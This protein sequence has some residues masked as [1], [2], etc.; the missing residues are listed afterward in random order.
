[1]KRW[2]SSLSARQRIL[3]IIGVVGVVALVAVSASTFLVRPTSVGANLSFSHHTGKFESDNAGSE[4]PRSDLGSP[5]QELYD[6]QAYPSTYIAPAQVSNA[7]NAYNGIVKGGDPNGKGA[8]WQPLGPST[9]NVP[10]EWSRSFGPKIESGRVTAI[11]VASTCNPGDCRLYLGA[12]GGGV[13]RTND[14]LA[15]PPSWTAMPNGMDSAAIGSLWVDPA[16]KDHVLVG[17]GEPNGSSDSEAGV[18]MYST[19]DGGAHWTLLAGSPA[20]AAGRSIASIDVDPHNASHIVIGTA[21]ARHGVSSVNGGRFTPPG[22]PTI[23]LYESTDGGAHFTLTFSQPSDP[24]DPTSPNGSDFFRGGVSKVSFDPT[25]TGRFYFSMFDYG[26]FRGTN[27]AFEQVFTAFD[28]GDP[29]NSANNRVEFAL[30]PLIDGSGKLRIYLADGRTGIAR[31][32]RTDDASIA[33]PVWQELSNS[34]ASNPNGF[35]SYDFCRTQTTSQ[36]SYDMVVTSPAGHPDTVWL[37][38]LFKYEELAGRSNS[39]AVQ[40]STN[41]GVSFTDMSYDM[42]FIG[43]HPDQHALAFDANNPDIAF[44]GSDGGI[45]RTSGTFSNMATDPNLGCNV[46][47]LGATSKA[48]CNAWLTAVPTRI[49]SMNAGLQTLQFQSVS[50]DPQNPSMLIGGTQDNG[51][52]MNGIQGGGTSDWLEAIGGDGGQSGINAAH[53]NISFHSFFNPAHDVNFHNGAPDQWDW[54]ADPLGNNEGASFYVPMIYDPNTAKADTMF[55]GEQHI[56]R[57]TDNGGPQAYLDQHCN[58]F[59]GDFAAKCGDWVPMGGVYANPNDPFPSTN[60][61]DAGDLS[62]TFFGADK[63]ASS[64]ADSAGNYVVAI[65]RTTSNTGTLWAGTRRGRVFISTNADASDASTV[66]YTRIDTPNTPTRFVSGI[67]VDPRNPNHAF[68]SF[69]GYDAYAQAA[70]TAK[71]HVF[72]VLYD[73]A[74]HTATW[75]DLS[76]GLGDQPITGI[77]FDP[78]ANDVYV[79]TDFGVLHNIGGGTS[80]WLPVGSGLPIVKV[81]GLTLVTTSTGHKLFAATHGRS[82]WAINLK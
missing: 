18:G 71:G 78:H 63:G 40:R 2:L 57:T 32:Y 79:S 55:E 29:A 37:S 23:G 52:W 58:E 59:T 42:N 72:D 8:T 16:N 14:A 60:L 66:S 10:V 4:A 67:A 80:H 17:T 53:S 65:A 48:L 62:G 75:T 41:A 33:T 7:R 22:A 19:T 1:M 9:G 30:A 54:I 15:T 5:N 47:G 12:A 13:W 44:A 25:T 20:A 82:I 77:A 56:F 26:L 11:G 28:A 31:F 24:V 64:P 36:C 74:T 39:R 43:M 61:N 81:N 46:R 70:G 76:S 50:V 49:Y 51:T 38:G 35:A 45:V 73:P 69:S 68:I 6:N 3:G 34:S 27:G 21:V